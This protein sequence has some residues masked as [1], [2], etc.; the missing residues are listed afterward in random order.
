[1]SVCRAFAHVDQLAD[2]RH[3]GG[4]HVGFAHQGNVASFQQVPWL[5]GERHQ[6]RARPLAVVEFDPGPVGNVRR[7]VVG[8]VRADHAAVDQRGWDIPGGR[9]Q[10]PPIG[11]GAADV[12]GAV[13]VGDLDLRP[14]PGALAHREAVAAHAVPALALHGLAEVIGP[15]RDHVPARTQRGG[16]VVGVVGLEAGIAAG[17]SPTHVGAVEVQHVAVRRRHVELRGR[18]CV[19]NLDRSARIEIEVV[20]LGFALDPNP[21]PDGPPGRCLRALHHL[22]HWPAL[23]RRGAGCHR[24]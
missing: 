4:R 17:R 23:M 13:G 9:G 2:E 14:Q 22:R 1:M 7:G 6:P 3:A 11:T 8:L 18:R 15:H 20:G 16:H 19:V 10:Q 21:L 5:L 12:R 24:K